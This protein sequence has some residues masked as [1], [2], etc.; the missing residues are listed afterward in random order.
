M[1][2][3]LNTKISQFASTKRIF[4]NTLTSVHEA[5]NEIRNEVY[6]NQI[7]EL[8][9]GNT[10]VKKDLK[11]VAFHGFFSGSRKKENFKESSGLII[12]DIDDV[13]KDEIEEYKEDIVASSD[14]VLAAMTS[15]SGNG[16]KLLYVVQKE[17][18]TADNYRKI[19]K[20]VSEKFSIYGDVDYLS[21][22]D[23]LIVTSDPFMQV[24]FEA[25]PDIIHI[26]D[27]VLPD[28]VL[29]PLDKGKT[30][31]SDPEEFFETVL[32]DSILELSNNNYHFIQVSVFELA[33]FGFQNSESDLSFVIDYAEESFKVSKEN[34][35]RF[36]H[37]VEV[38]KTLGQT[39]HPYN[40]TESDEN[41]DYSDFM[42]PEEYCVED[43]IKASE[44]DALDGMVD[45]TNFTQSVEE[46]INEG[47]RV[48]REISLSNFADIFRFKGTGVL[49]FTGIP[50]HGKTEFLDSIILDLARLH[51]EETIIMG[52][53]QTPQVH[54][55]K[56]VRKLIG[57]NISSK[58]W[59]EGNNT[60]RL[61]E[62]I[63]F[64][65]EFIKHVDTPKVGSNTN[66]L[67]KVASNQIKKDRSKGKAVKYVVIDPFNMLSIKG[68]VS[69]HE[70]IEEILRKITQFS[71]EME[72]LVFLVAHPT[73]MKKDEQTGKFEV[74]DFYSV[75][76]SS[77]FYEM[78]Y[79]GLVIY[80][81]GYEADDLVFVK[82]LKVKQS[83]LGITGE[84]AFFR[85]H[86]ESGRYIP[87]DEEGNELQGDHYEKDWF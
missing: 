63:A 28:T 84:S 75:K 72:V 33:K 86:R 24:N 51:H 73:K 22:T 23:C 60:E 30:L 42:E 59:L 81:T 46:V 76:G 69:G 35:T 31:W 78:S 49:T 5:L 68:R 8:R 61:H 52:F 29:P 64:V 1:N 44:N 12:I 37:A 21:I 32:L 87:T 13:E 6:E 19:G 54:V 83:N 50:S 2:E 36:L 9:S 80:R 57:S 58:Q 11:T 27:T 79:H 20:T 55:S 82:V 70:K 41:D 16:I 4:D 67:L 34:K 7:S 62:G 74:P 65:T 26:K 10:D 18:V 53:E 15:P 3:L 39:N 77:A 56:L 43:G 45:Y 38:A 17:F 85:Y 66:T 47:D 48:G 25:Y 40:T 14:H 71:H